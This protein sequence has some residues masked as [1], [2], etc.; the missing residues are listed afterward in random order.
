MSV[1][2]WLTKSTKT[3]IYT[4]VE[5]L[6][7]CVLMFNLTFDVL[8]SIHCI[9]EYQHQYKM[10]NLTFGE[11][12][13]IKSNRN[14]FVF[15]L[16]LSTL[17]YAIIMFLLSKQVFSRLLLF[18]FM[19]AIC[20]ETVFELIAAYHANDQ[21]VLIYKFIFIAPRLATLLIAAIYF[22]SQKLSN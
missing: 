22:F 4:K 18:L 6:F 14:F 12:E 3:K 20:V 8:F 15:T 21:S 9:R 13:S 10:P 17:L 2:V 16:L 11:K 19:G 5:I 7:I 1:N